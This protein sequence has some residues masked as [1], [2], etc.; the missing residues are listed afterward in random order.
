MLSKYIIQK[1]MIQVLTSEILLLIEKIK[2][3]INIKRGDLNEI[4]MNH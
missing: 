4:Q 2:I 3:V 1:I